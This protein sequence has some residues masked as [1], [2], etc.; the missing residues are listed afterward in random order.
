MRF[1]EKFNRTGWSILLTVLIGL[2]AVHRASAHAYLLHSEPAANAILDTAPETMRLWFSEIISSEFSGAMLLDADGQSLDITVT[3]DPNDHTLLVVNLPELPDGVYSLRWAAHSEADGHSTQGLIVFGIGEGADLGT[4]TAVATDTAVSWPEVVLRWFTYTLILGLVGMVAVTTLVLKPANFSDNVAAVLRA[5]Q[6]RILRIAWRLSLASL[7]VGVIWVG[8]Q[9]YALASSVSGNISLL[10]TAWQWL[11]QTRLG[12]FWWARQM[13]LL[14]LAAS[15]WPGERQMERETAVSPTQRIF[16]FVLLLTLLVVQSLTSHAAALTSQTTLAVTMNTL[17]L[18][19]AGLWVGGLLA[20]V[21]GLLPLVRQKDDFTALVQAG[22]GPFGRLAA[23]SVVLVLAT[24]IYSTGREVGSADAMIST[25]YGQTLMVKIGLMLTVGLF[26]ALNSS[27]LHPRLSAPLAHL[28]HKLQGWTP[29]SARRLPRLIVA[30]VIVG[31]LVLLLAGL[32]T[33]APT[34]RGVAIAANRNAPSSLSQRVDDMV[35]GLSV[36]P[37]QA[38]Q[39]IFTVRAASTR[40]PTPAK[41]LRIILRFTYLGQDL[42]MA[43]V[44]AAEIEP[45]L[46]LIG[47]SQLNVAGNWQIDVVVRRQG[48]EDSIASFEWT[49]PETGP[50][51]PVIISNRPWEPLLTALAM[52]LLLLL[53]GTAVISIIKAKNSHL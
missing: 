27:I 5:A 44:D 40:R 2:V 17:H 7:L 39:N 42:G 30:E 8:W 6:K 13:V 46:Y 18:V 24:G 38:G 20:L 45:D 35:I 28:L 10:A 1:H 41:V 29:I 4:A 50:Q 14:V 12:L 33:A 25:F 3:V 37:N 11:S 32:V 16:L 31:L 47:G 26:G 48:L 9:A 51:Q 53:G 52:V 19:A 49:V 34:A 36:N 43:S 15:L 21:V 23:F 22:W